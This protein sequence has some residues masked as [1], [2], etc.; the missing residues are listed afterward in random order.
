MKPIP[1]SYR[2]CRSGFHFVFASHSQ[3]SGVKVAKPLESLVMV[4]QLRRLASRCSGQR[5]QILL[6]S[7]LKFSFLV[8]QFSSR[9]PFKQR[10]TRPGLSFAQITIDLSRYKMGRIGAISPTSLFR[11]GR[12]IPQVSRPMSFDSIDGQ[13]SSEIP[14]LRRC[15]FMAGKVQTRRPTRGLYP[16][17]PLPVSS[18][19][20]LRYETS[21]QT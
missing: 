12:F 16:F 19:T 8:P 3:P 20:M 18:L 6:G 9:Q 5:V 4:S 10:S 17:T 15:R 7:D 2:R 11:H 14:S 13:G 1:P 21:L